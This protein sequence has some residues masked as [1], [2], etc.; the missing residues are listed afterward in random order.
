MNQ[1]MGHEN[2]VPSFQGGNVN[3][4]VGHENHIPTFQGGFV[5]LWS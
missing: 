4:Q 2:H 3:Q 5:C 1:Q